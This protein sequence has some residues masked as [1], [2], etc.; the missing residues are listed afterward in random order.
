MGRF[1]RHPDDHDHE[2]ETRDVGDHSGYRQTGTVRVAVLENLLA[3]NDRI[4]M[5]NRADLAAAALPSCR[6]REQARR[7]C[8]AAR[9]RPSPAR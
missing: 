1:H 5:A 8:C 7:R 3:E 4:A 2:H 9:S 6:H